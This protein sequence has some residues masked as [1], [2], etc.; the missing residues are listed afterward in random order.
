MIDLRREEISFIRKALN[1][2]ER[3]PIQV[4]SLH[5]GGSKRSF[6]RIIYTDNLTAIFMSYDLSRKED[7]YY[8]SIAF[9]LEKIGIPIPKIIG[10][11]PVKG[12]VVMED[13]GDKDLYSFRLSPWETKSVYYRKTLEIMLKL[14][15]YPTD[16]FPDENISLMEGFDKDLYRWEANY[17][18]ENF[19]QAVCGIDINQSDKSKL[20]REWTCLSERLNIASQRLVHRDF[21]SQNV[22][23]KNGSPVI[24]DFQGMRFGNPLYDLTS[25]L[26]D[27]YVKF[28]Q[29][30]RMELLLYYFNMLKQNHKGEK[31]V[32]LA[33]YQRKDNHTIDVCSLEWTDFQ[34]MFWEASAQRLM[35]ALGAYGFLGLKL[36][37]RN[38]LSYIPQGL[39]NLIDATTRAK[40]LKLLRNLAVQ[41]SRVLRKSI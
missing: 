16:N 19:V 18:Y 4:F 39:E 28:S 5:G 13:M 1:I 35:Q 31:G 8:V 33:S 38:F 15:T 24:I 9:F 26:C 20:E 2:D 34:K 7:T 27:P 30:E 14:H 12:F 21:Q 17:F 41:C 6:R 10:H 36:G 29:S 37:L 3:I 22:M 23:M 25:L 11:D 40:E 32:R